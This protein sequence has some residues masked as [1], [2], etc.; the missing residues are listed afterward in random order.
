M[1]F[2]YLLLSYYPNWISKLP[3][4]GAWM[5]YFKQFMAFPMFATIIWLLWVF[6]QQTSFTGLLFLQLGMLTAGLAA[7]IYGKFC[8]YS[9]SGS[10]KVVALITCLILGMA[11]LML[12]IKGVQAGGN[13]TVNIAKSNSYGGLDYE[14][15]SKERL[16]ELLNEKRSIYI[17]FTA[18]WC[19]TCQANK[20]LVF[21]SAEVIEYFRE[22][23]IAL[24]QGDWTKR[25]EKITEALKGYGRSGVPTNVIYIDGD[26]SNYVVM[27]E[28]LTPG[29][30]LEAFRK[31]NL[32]T[33][34]L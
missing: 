22:N 8:G 5:E 30:V 29:I 2:P 4:P 15:Y 23:K 32:A 24:L 13:Q 18:S 11:S 34:G 12:C 19:L 31:G 3:K 25:D 20:K 28:V 21:S 1:S 7:W 9:N 33:G 27:P 26:N 10:S 6:G 17:D 14:A 16:D